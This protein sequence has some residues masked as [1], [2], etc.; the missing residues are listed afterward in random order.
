MN[1]KK[2]AIFGI[3]TCVTLVVLVAIWA[4]RDGLTMGELVDLGMTAV[5]TKTE[6]HTIADRVAAIEAK[7]PDLK[8]RALEANGKLRILVFKTERRVELHAPGWKQAR[9]YPMTAFSGT[10]GP[11]LREGDGQIPEG[12]YGIEYLNPN[13]RFYLSLKVSYPNADDKA[14]AAKDGR[15]QLGGDIMIHGKNAT[16]GCIPIGDEAI[17]DVFYLVQA[18]GLANVTVVI[19]P[20]DMRAGRQPDLEKSDLPW[21]AELCESLAAHLNQ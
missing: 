3:A 6:R 7:K 5:R 21:Y 15:T 12:I 19:A 11:K 1:M 16:V 2:V 10:L 18:V 17:E 13:S 9:V 20:Y 8:Q 4:G 14:R